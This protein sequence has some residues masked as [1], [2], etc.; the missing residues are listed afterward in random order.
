MA[1]PLEPAHESLPHGSAPIQ[2]DQEWANALTHA[3]GTIAAA[4]AGAWMVLAAAE[5]EWGLSVAVAA[6]A[7][8][9][10][11]V[12]LF[13]TL[14]HVFLK[15]PLL[16]VFRAWDQAMIYTM[17][18]GTYTP[19]AYAY[20]PP[21]TRVWLLTAIWVA[22]AAGFA[23]KVF[24]RHRINSIGTLSYLLLGWLPAIP[25]A[26]HVPRSLVLMM[27]LGGI[28]YTLGV[29]FLVNDRRYRYLHAVWHLFVL[30]AA[31]SHYIGIWRDIVAVPH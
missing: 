17:I 6:Y 1:E 9:A 29:V 28:L 23:H 31:S 13:S 4:V 14:S 11:G 30:A 21:G 10:L 22:A 19:I 25:L 5:I 27:L 15:Q 2:Q 16:D 8:S 7:L 20:A 12:F 24:V 3:I 26:G 18:S